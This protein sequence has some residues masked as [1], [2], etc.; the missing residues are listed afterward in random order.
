MC[1][2]RWAIK[3]TTIIKRWAIKKTMCVKRGGPIRVRQG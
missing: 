3:K 1:V 2:K